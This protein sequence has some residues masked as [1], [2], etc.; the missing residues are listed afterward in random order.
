MNA[1][2]EISMQI[3]Q[4]LPVIAREEQPKQSLTVELVKR[5]SKRLVIMKERLT[6]TKKIIIFNCQLDKGKTCEA[7]RAGR[8]F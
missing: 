8:N 4:Q 2:T 7:V 3:K 1:R 5:T 6:T